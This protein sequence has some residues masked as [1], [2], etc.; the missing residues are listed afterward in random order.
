MRQDSERSSDG[1]TCRGGNKA[2]ARMVLM[3]LHLL[4]M[5]R[6]GTADPGSQDSARYVVYV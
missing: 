4:L 6:G 2:K 1:Y 3:A 5:Q